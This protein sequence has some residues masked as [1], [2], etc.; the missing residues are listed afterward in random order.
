MLTTDGKIS[1]AM[2]KVL[3]IKLSERDFRISGRL[4]VHTLA[5]A[6]AHA[7]YNKPYTLS[8]GG[9]IGKAQPRSKSWKYTRFV[10]HVPPK[11]FF[12]ITPKWNGRKRET[13]LVAWNDIQS[14]LSHATS[15]GG[16]VQYVEDER[17]MKG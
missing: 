7:V 12:E 2:E 9:I 1:F 6:I 11:K 14:M 3:E 17:F 5:S 15:T 16:S 4:A 13:W 10:V 8:S